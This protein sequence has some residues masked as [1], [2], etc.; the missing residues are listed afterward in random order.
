MTR[1]AR[2]RNNYVPIAS[3]NGG[4]SLSETW[5]K[6]AASNSSGMMTDLWGG[7]VGSAMADGGLR[8]EAVA[9]L[10]A[11][12]LGRADTIVRGCG[13]G[14]EPGHDAST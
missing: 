6:P 7:P 1:S 11:Q 9:I 3:G 13:T 12:D 2:G 5:H 8:F 14:G 10:R 4:V